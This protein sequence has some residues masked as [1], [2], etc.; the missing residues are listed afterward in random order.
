MVSTKQHQAAELPAKI[1]I[2]F[3]WCTVNRK[4]RKWFQECTVDFNNQRVNNLVYS[5]KKRHNGHARNDMK[6]GSNRSWT[7]KIATNQKANSI[8]WWCPDMIWIQNK[9]TRGTDVP[10][11]RQRKVKMAPVC[12]C[13]KLDRYV[14]HM[15]NISHKR[16]L[17]FP[18][19]KNTFRSVQNSYASIPGAL[20]CG[21]LV[22]GFLYF[23]DLLDDLLLLNQEST[24]DPAHE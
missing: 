1:D 17:D 8:S 21:C 3:E 15:L 14:S 16:Q 23:Q 12:R 18:S 9:A 5:C 22:L 20:L 11:F 10:I 24:D 13:S 2:R 7:K 19:T 4:A 6:R